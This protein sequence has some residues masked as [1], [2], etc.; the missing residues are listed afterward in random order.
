MPEQ[1]KMSLAALKQDFFKDI[2]E[3]SDNYIYSYV[4][5]TFVFYWYFWKQKKCFTVLYDLVNTAANI[6]IFYKND[7]F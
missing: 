5:S 3:W 2:T 1:L 7:V 6:Y 4:L